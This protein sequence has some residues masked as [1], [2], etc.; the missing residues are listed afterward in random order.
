VSA[1]SSVR[2][3]LEELFSAALDAVEPAR[4]VREAVRREGDRIA[5]AGEPL[6]PGARLIVL[7]VGKA[8]GRMARALEDVVGDQIA[9]GLVVVPDGLAVKLN[10]MAVCETAHPVPDARCERAGRM[11]ID[12][13][14]GAR[15][16]DVLVAL[17]SGGASSLLS[18]PV[19]GISLSELATT[20][21]LLL[22]GGA[23]I[24]ELN[25]VR[26]HLSRIAGGRLTTHAVCRRIEVLAIS[27]VPGDRLDVI[28]SGPLA[29]DSTTYRDALGVVSLRAAGI[30]QRVREHLVAGA[31]GDIEET[32]APGAAVFDRVRSTV[33]ASNATAVAAACAAAERSGLRA[34]ALPAALA[35][36]A[37]VAGRRLAALGLSMRT[38]QPICAIAGGETAVIVRGGGIGGRNQEL[39]LTAAVELEGRRN[40]AL[41]AAGT[42][43]IDGPTD[44]AGAFANGDTVIHGR[45][46]GLDARAALADNDSHTFFDREGGVL[47]TGATGTNVMDLAFL[48]VEP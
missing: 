16:G 15:P 3:R 33:L 11:A 12:L 21:S 44:A 1:V 27:D 26:K 28:G 37:R 42:D 13:V 32:P 17:I 23:A 48:H 6:P 46:L 4:A 43:G 41:L 31:R 20:T 34:F 22:E 8:A 35:G 38:A 14:A 2:N 39:A 25:A 5:I 36:E 19:D 45:S 7:A 40:I 24:H 29:G 18:C 30:P 9:G 47:R 10:N